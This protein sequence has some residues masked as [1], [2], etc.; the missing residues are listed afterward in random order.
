MA[1]YFKKI[2]LMLLLTSVLFLSGCFYLRLHHVQKQLGN[3]EHYYEIQEGEFL[4]FIA[5][6]PIL[7]SADVVR[8]MRC[9]PSL[10][11][12]N[13]PNF[14]FYYTLE[15]KYPKNVSEP[16][17]YSV[18]IAFVFEDDKL[19][20]TLIDQ[21]LFAAIPKKTFIDIVKAF[22]T[23]KVD[24]R[25]QSVS[26]TAGSKAA[27]LQLPDSNEV[28]RLLGQPYSV[29]GR[30]YTYKY[31]WKLPEGSKTSPNVIEAV[32]TFNEKDKLLKC[33]SNILGSPMGLDFSS[34]YQKTDSPDKQS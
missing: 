29:E 5:K 28:L 11:D 9:P 31:M 20:K 2:I 7:F 33:S 26:A 14:V 15:K 17:N 24:T 13:E 22:G 27:Q 3:F 32:F 4:S 12:G 23:A 21:R 34:L 16:E 18:T 10:I 6:E 30:N 19:A 1:R 8:L 25:S